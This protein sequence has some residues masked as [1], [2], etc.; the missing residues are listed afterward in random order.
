MK[1]KF[2]V[3]RKAAAALAG[4]YKNRNLREFIPRRIDDRITYA[5]NLSDEVERERQYQEIAKFV[6]S[7]ERQLVVQNLYHKDKTVL[8]N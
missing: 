5:V 4:Q 1:D 6:E 8:D 3:L 7:C 2:E